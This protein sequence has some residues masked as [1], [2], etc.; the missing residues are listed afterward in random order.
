[1]AVNI[2]PLLFPAENRSQACVVIDAHNDSLPADGKEEKTESFKFAKSVFF[3]PNIKS[4][5]LPMRFC[6]HP[7]RSKRQVFLPII[8]PPPKAIA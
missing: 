3:V 8:L 7:L 1:M 2:A 6:E 5:T 4:E